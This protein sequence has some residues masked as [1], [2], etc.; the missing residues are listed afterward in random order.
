[1]PS[2]EKLKQEYIWVHVL[3]NIS[4]FTGSDGKYYR[5]L[6]KHDIVKIPKLD[7]EK[8]I[9]EN[10]VELTVLTPEQLEKIWKEARK[11]LRDAGIR[12]VEIYRDK[13]LSCLKYQIGFED[14]LAIAKGEARKIIEEITKA[15]M[16]KPSLE[17]VPEIKKII[18]E[19]I[20]RA[21]A[22]PP[23]APP[24]PKSW[25]EVEEDAYRIWGEKGREEIRKYREKLEKEKRRRSC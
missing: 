21:F 13:I 14:N 25:E 9:K 17:K 15:Y 23:W 11:I 7:Y 2:E 10:L 18:R 4:E 20:R 1:M 19:E 22:P 24:Y 6:Y 5:P 3:T 8:F 16:A 12:E